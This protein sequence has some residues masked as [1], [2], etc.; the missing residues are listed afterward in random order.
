MIVNTATGKPFSYRDACIEMGPTVG[1]DKQAAD[2]AATQ[3][4]ALQRCCDSR[5][6]WAN[7]TL[8]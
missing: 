8:F 4:S 6:R 2:A 1:Y 3:V 7:R 5:F